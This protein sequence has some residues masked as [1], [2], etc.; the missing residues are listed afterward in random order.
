MYLRICGCRRRSAE[1]ASSSSWLEAEEARPRPAGAGDPAGDLGQG[2][3]ALALIEHAIVENPDLMR[4]PVPLAQQ[5]G[6]GR[7]EERRVGKRVDLGG[8]RIIK[9]KKRRRQRSAT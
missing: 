4:D 2:A 6:A 8:R 3:I 7:S 5:H 1:P 9:K